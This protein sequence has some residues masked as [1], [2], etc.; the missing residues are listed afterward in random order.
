MYLFSNRIIY[1]CILICIFI[2]KGF[3]PIIIENCLEGD[4]LR[5]DVAQLEKT[6]VS[7]GPDSIAAI[8][9]T[10]SCFAPRGIDKLE[11]VLR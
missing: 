5:T 10:T 6:L 8:M 3:E 11:E 4:E 2:S 1:L 7:L 9:T